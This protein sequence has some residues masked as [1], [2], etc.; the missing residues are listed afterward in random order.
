MSCDS[1]PEAYLEARLAGALDADL[2]WRAADMDCEGMRRPDARGLRVTFTGSVA[3]ERL[4]LIFGAPTLAEGADGRALP[5]NVT[6]IRDGGRVYGTRGEHKCTLD[7]VHQRRRPPSAD[8]ANAT[9]D[10]TATR[11]WRIDGKG[12]CLEPARSV[13]G[14]SDAILLMRF[15]FAGIVGWQPDPPDP[16]APTISGAPEPAAHADTATH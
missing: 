14:S 16:P 7:D 8:G 1:L 3:G 6:L 2:H 12:F 10:A 13:S 4:T 9:A 11:P 5:V 15:D